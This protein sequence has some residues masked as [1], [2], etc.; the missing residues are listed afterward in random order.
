MEKEVKVSISILNSNFLNLEKEILRA[1]E[2]GIDWLHF[3]VM[4]GH[5]VPNISFGAP[6]LSCIGH[7]F[8]MFNDVHLMISE[9]EKYYEDFIKAGADL[10]TF[11]YEA[12]D[13][14][15]KIHDLIDKIHEKNTKV[16]ISIKPNTDVKVLLPFLD[17]LDLVLI[18][19]V[20]PGF[21]GQKF[22]LT[23]LDKIR[24]L[25]E[26][27]IKNGLKY[28]IEVDG[29]INDTTFKLCKK[30]GVDICVIGSY[31]YRSDNMLESYKK[32]ED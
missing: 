23:S 1:K 32:L 31:L 25:S 2:I 18:M 20:E 6:I 19:S 15:Q 3:D 24:I 8:N 12:I 26:Y 13:S 28:L 30:D 16:G 5:F 27:K 29:G 21:G 7:K 11:H 22:I 14:A 17:K 9:P 10:I 4:D